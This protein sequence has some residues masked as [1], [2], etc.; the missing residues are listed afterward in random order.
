MLPW[1]LIEGLF[2]HFLLLPPLLCC[3]PADVVAARACPATPCAAI[4]PACQCAEAF[5]LDG[6]DVRV[7]GQSAQQ[8]KRLCPAGCVNSLL[9][10]QL[11][12]QGS[13]Q[14]DHNVLQLPT[15]K[16][17]HQMHPT[18]CGREESELSDKMRPSHP[19]QSWWCSLQE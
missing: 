6:R 4:A 10:I 17:K 9:L 14:A 13:K 19:A 16:G 2:H 15:M 12:P 11:F 8:A 3:W 7:D 18:R 5:N 1:E